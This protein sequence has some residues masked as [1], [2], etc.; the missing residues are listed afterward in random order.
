MAGV[1]VYCE[2]VERDR[3]SRLIANVFSF[4]GV[5]IGRRLASVGWRWAY[6]G[7]FQ[8]LSG[9]RLSTFVKPGFPGYQLPK[10]DHASFQRGR[11]DCNGR[12]AA[13]TSSEVAQNRSFGLAPRV[14]VTFERFSGDHGRTSPVGLLSLMARDAQAGNGGG[15]GLSRSIRRRISANKVRGT[16]TSA[17]WN[18]T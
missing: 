11:Q 15:R 16:A 1:K 12:K 4:T 3:H 10:A 7:R 6:G 2:V 18:T 17:S 14:G 8:P 9:G 5:D 13:A